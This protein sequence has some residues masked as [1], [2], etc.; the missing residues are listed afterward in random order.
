[1]AITWSHHAGKRQ[2]NDSGRLRA[3][4]NRLRCNQDCN[5]T[6]LLPPRAVS[7]FGRCAH[8]VISYSGA[9]Y[10]GSEPTDTWIARRVSELLGFEQPLGTGMGGAPARVSRCDAGTTFHRLLRSLERDTA[11][12]DSSLRPQLCATG[13]LWRRPRNRAFVWRTRRHGRRIE[14]VRSARHLP[15]V[16]VSATPS[17]I[18]SRTDLDEIAASLRH[19]ASRETAR[20]IAVQAIRGAAVRLPVTIG[21][22]CMEVF[23]PRQ[24]R[25]GIEAAYWPDATAAHAYGPWLITPAGMCSPMEFTGAVVARSL[26]PS[27]FTMECNDWFSPPDP[28]VFGLNV[29]ERRPA[30]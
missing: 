26:G 10:I 17:G 22:D 21:R 19:G 18:L 13:W 20:S 2:Q 30:P 1:V 7:A 15:D 16:T 29:Q 9:A 12:V 24:F 11:R 28:L 5:Q 23:L 14:F 4:K 8:M 3:R 25:D 6:I 27:R